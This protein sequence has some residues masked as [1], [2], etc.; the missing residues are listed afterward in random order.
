MPHNQHNTPTPSNTPDA[1]QRLII[2][3]AVLKRL[4]AAH[5]DYKQQVAKGFTPGDKRAV[6]NP[7]GLAL[8]SVSM[9]APN[10]KAVCK[11]QSIILAEAQ[12]RGMEIIDA[13]PPTDSEA[14]QEAIAVLLEHAPHLL[15]SDV[16]K[17]DR[18]EIADTILEHWQITGAIPT[19]WTIEDASAPR[20][21][22]TP[23]RSKAAQSAIE[24]LVGEIDTILTPK[25]ITTGKDEQ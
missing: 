21:S 15:T 7:Q 23:G 25:A 9:S 4:Y 19:G 22:I 13:L 3:A 17:E 24:H 18:E 10:K 6:K 2:E 8:G 11:D 16:S 14:G 1:L 12:E 5:A 20:F